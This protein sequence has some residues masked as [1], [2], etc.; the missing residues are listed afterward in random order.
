MNEFAVH[1]F[2]IFATPSEELSVKQIILELTPDEA[3]KLEKYCEWTG[4]TATDVIRELIQ[5]LPIT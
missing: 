1:I 3:K 5:D 2:P 4:K